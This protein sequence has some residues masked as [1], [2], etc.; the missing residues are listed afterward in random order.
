MLLLIDTFKDPTLLL[1]MAI[2]LSG[3]VTLCALTY[4]MRWLPWKANPAPDVESEAG[5]AACM[6]LPFVSASIKVHTKSSSG[7]GRMMEKIE[8]ELVTA[9]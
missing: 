5:T 1:E 2:S 9:D 8:D 7:G 3:L 4:G 6:D